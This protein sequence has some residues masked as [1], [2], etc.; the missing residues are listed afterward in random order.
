MNKLQTYIKALISAL[1]DL[2][3]PKD[4]LCL[5]CDRVIA[6]DAQDGLC[7][8]CVEELEELEAWQQT[9]EI[10]P[11]PGIVRAAAA[12]PYTA[13]ARRLIIRLKYEH[14]RDAAVP[15]AR[16]MAMLPGGEADALVP[17]PTTK[18]RLRARGYNQA[19]VLAE[20]VARETGMPVSAAITRTDERAAQV[21]LSG[22]SR[23]QNLTGTMK[24]DERIKG[25]R[26]LLIDDV[27]T[28]GSTAAEAARA[29]LDAGALSVEVFTAAKSVY[30][31][32][33]GSGQS[34]AGG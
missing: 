31:G 6:P 15:L 19:Q 20:L 18:R 25:K 11:A 2:L 17:V 4:V 21:K 7:P 24:A 26:V 8:A 27:Y 13:Q 30:D 5:C 29:L 32:G 22:Q 12:Y 16:A 23:R 9:Q 34:D 1:L 3:Y 14:V 10:V 28:T 33:S